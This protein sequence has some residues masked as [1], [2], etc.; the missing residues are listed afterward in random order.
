MK[1]AVSGAGIAGPTLA[2]WLSRSGHQP[3]LIET[4]PR[5]RTGGYVVDFWGAG[6]AIAE[7]MG[8]A[9]AVQAAGYAIEE[10]RLI[11]RSGCKTGGFGV[12]PFRRVFDGRFTSV[13]RGELARLIYQAID[14]EVE[15]VFNDHIA[16]VDQRDGGVQVTFAGGLRR[17]FDLVIGADG[18]HSSVRGAVFGPESQFTADLGY[19][20]AACETAGYRP[21]DELV[22]LAYSQPGRMVARFAL[23]GDRTMFL[24]VFSDDRV[25]AAD[26]GDEPDGRAILRRVFGADGWECPQILAEVDRADDLYFDRVSQIGMGRW[27]DGR[28]A[29]IGD[30]ASCVS[31]LA[32]EGTGLAMLQAYVLAGELAAAG[33]DHREAF[34][35]Y[36]QLLRPLIEDKQR[37]ARAF[38]AAFAPKTPAGLWIRN[39]VSRLLDVP[40]LAQWAIRR[41]FGDDI[42][43]PEYAM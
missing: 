17:E 25:R 18:I 42:P 10:V 22:Y 16:A 21:R 31:L 39:R 27:S 11:D 24:F 30:A 2:Y 41:E 12:G 14:G 7:R 40:G 28:V 8:L 23:R 29:L 4:A 9:A 36:E 33:G 19:W 26:L 6:Y 3:V 34:R 15:T 32:G 43:L 20:V 13:P 35:R 37:S 5:L 1:I 38:A